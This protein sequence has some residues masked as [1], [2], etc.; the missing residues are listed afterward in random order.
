M[1]FEVAVVAV[2]L[3]LNDAIAAAGP[4]TKVAAGIVI[5]SVAV[6]AVF[7][8]ASDPVAA[9]GQPAGIGAAILI[10]T[11]TVITIFKALIFRIEVLSHH[12]IATAGESAVVGASI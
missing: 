5:D 6:V 10:D 2:F 8:E 3:A 11:I 1:V 12:A 4:F 7:E 9:L